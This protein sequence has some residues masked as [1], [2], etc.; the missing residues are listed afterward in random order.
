MRK[1]AL[2]KVVK[3]ILKTICA[4]V[5]IFVL[6]ILIVVFIRSP[7]ELNTYVDE[8]NKVLEGSIAEKVFVEINGV[9][10][11]MIITGENTENP[12]LLFVH[13]GPG[14]PEYFLADKSA[15]GLEKHFTVCWW[16]Q[17]GAGLSY[18]ADTD[19]DN[20]TVD[21]F[22]DDTIAVTNYLRERFDQDKIYLMA[23]SWGTFIGIQAAA[24]APQL[25]AAY[26]AIAQIA[27]PYE[28]EQIAYDYML[29]QYENMGNSSMVKKLTDYA[30][31]EQGTFIEEYLS[32]S[33]RDEAMHELGI[34]TTHD[35]TSVISGVF[36][37]V[38]W[39]RA[40]TVSE[41]INIWRG[42]SFS[43]A[44]GL[45]DEMFST[46]L[47]QLVA[48]LDVPIYFMSGIYD[49]TVSYQL[50][51]EYYEQIEAPIKAFYTF[52]DSAHSPIFEESDRFVQILV[53]DVLE[54]KTALSDF[55]Q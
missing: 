43:K 29:E 25:Y 41:K 26:I 36:F 32:S 12:V 44:A 17:R 31:A 10:Q 33:L 7:G 20:M 8:N 2:F 37:P 51:N 45:N 4:S 48:G 14:M 50:A 5:L 30:G 24:E 38:W 23:H 47:M 49:Y 13:G 21:Q 1:S 54:G 39:C 55:P 3:R 28:S 6:L 35:M 18:N 9:E 34:G 46:D 11:G 19:P 40:Y 52:H 53:E 42:K 16:E 22:I 15:T 27:N